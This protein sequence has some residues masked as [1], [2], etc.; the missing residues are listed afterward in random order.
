MT[1]QQIESTRCDQDGCIGV[2]LSTTTG[3][4][5]HFAELAPDVFDAE[6]TRIGTEGTVDAR[7]VLI[8]VDLPERLL[9]AAP[10]VD[11]RPT[12]ATARFDGATFQGQAHFDRVRFQGEARFEGAT[13]RATAS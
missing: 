3:C 6:L 5:T 2:R 7:G 1:G 12:L 9:T 8:S 13:F 10:E 4:L 11:G